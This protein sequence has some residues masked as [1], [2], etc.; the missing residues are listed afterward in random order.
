MTAVPASR[1]LIEL[2]P[3][4]LKP[5]P[6]TG[7]HRA[8]VGDPA[9][10]IVVAAQPDFAPAIDDAYRQG[11]EAGRREAL[12]EL[13]EEHEQAVK[14]LSQEA[15]DRLRRAATDLGTRLNVG[16]A[17]VRSSISDSVAEA[18]QPM[19][20]RWVRAEAMQLLSEKLGVILGGRTGLKIIVNGPDDLLAALRPTLEGT[21]H[22]LQFERADRVDLHISLDQLVV[23]T[24]IAAWISAIEAGT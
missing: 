19:I 14:R 10:T 22:E 11:K 17:E 15:S 1:L 13:A 6:R 12:A 5:R 8:G 16:L 4:G 18:L 24:R 21:G 23:E 3:S 2:D 9:A 20:G 7:I